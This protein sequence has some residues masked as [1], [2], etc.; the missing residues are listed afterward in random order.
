MCRQFFKSPAFCRRWSVPQHKRSDHISQKI[1]SL[2]L[3]P[4]K[5]PTVPVRKATE[6]D[7]AGLFRM[8]LQRESLK[9]LAQCL[10]EAFCLVR[11]LKAD[12]EIV[13]PS[14]D[15]D[16]TFRMALSPVLCPQIEH[17]VEIDVGEQRRNRRPLRGPFLARRPYSPFEYSGLQP[18]SDESEH[19]PIG[20]TMLEESHHPIVINSVEVSRN[21]RI[22]YP[23]DL[24]ETNCGS[25]DIE[26]HMRLTSWSKPVAEAEEV[27]LV[28]RDEP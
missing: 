6:S 27:R 3:S 2:G 10:G 19:P 28:G 8:K 11:M 14:N 9:P 15:D 13:G 26:R 7:Q 25:Q 21:I 20:D 5:T 12:D 23:A 16:I 17:I 24:L 18:L 4:A 22:E 1:E